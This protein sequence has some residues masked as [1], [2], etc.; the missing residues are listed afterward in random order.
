MDEQKYQRRLNQYQRFRKDHG[1][2]EGNRKY[3]HFL[4]K[5]YKS[6]ILKEEDMAGWEIS[7]VKKHYS[8]V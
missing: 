8:I 5:S 1:L 6:K 2:L 7:L 4:F 3:A